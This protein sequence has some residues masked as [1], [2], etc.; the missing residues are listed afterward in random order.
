MFLTSPLSGP[1]L[2]GGDTATESLSETLG[3]VRRRLI[4][5]TGDR[6][7]WRWTDKRDDKIIK[8]INET[9]NPW[10]AEERQRLRLT[11]IVCLVVSARLWGRGGAGGGVGVRRGDGRGGGLRSGA[12]RR[13]ARQAEL[14]VGRRRQRPEHLVHL[15]IQAWRPVRPI[16]LKHI[17]H[18]FTQEISQLALPSYCA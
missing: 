8:G 3:E 7:C 4:E 9:R 5:R 16:V 10:N 6:T 1:A 15:L 12:G 2:P 18:F 11:D 14:G 17:T 13:Q